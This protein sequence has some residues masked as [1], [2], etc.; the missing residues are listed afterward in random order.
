MSDI[1]NGNTCKRCEGEGKITCP[2]CKG[3]GEIKKLYYNLT[4]V[5][6][7]EV[8]ESCML[9]GGKGGIECPNCS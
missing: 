6:D 3:K 4:T 5:G 8:V 7:D 1:D 9:C 2:K